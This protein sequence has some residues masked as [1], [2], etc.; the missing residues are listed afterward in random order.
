MWSESEVKLT[1]RSSSSFSSDRLDT[2]IVP[3]NFTPLQDIPAHRKQLALQKKSNP[4]LKS[5]LYTW[6]EILAV[7][8]KCI[9]RAR[10]G[11][12]ESKWNLSFRIRVDLVV[13]INII[14]KDSWFT[15][16][17]Y[18]AVGKNSSVL[19]FFNTMCQ[20]NAEPLLELYSHRDW[21]SCLKCYLILKKKDWNQKHLTPWY[22]WIMCIFNQIT[23]ELKRKWCLADLEDLHL[24]GKIICCSIK[25]K[26]E[27]L[28]IQHSQWRFFTVFPQW[29]LKLGLTLIIFQN[30]C[31]NI[32]R[33]LSSW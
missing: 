6:L 7:I 30:N 31:S 17:A 27:H 5:P 11:D 12:T 25:V 23:C 26:H 32:L 18:T 33:E 15:I 20:H 22:K 13:I 29:P 4:M 19:Y 28:T 8:V 21:L 2:S 16:M 3:L 10:A 24:A 9:P 14:S 1:S